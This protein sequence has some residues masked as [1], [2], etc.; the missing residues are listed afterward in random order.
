MYSRRAFLAALPAVFSLRGAQGRR[1]PNIL[2]FL[3]DDQ[4][5]D[6]AGFMGN[7]IL[8]TPAADRLASSGVVFTN[9]F[10]T[11]SICMSSRASILTGLYERCHHINLFT[12]PLTDAQFQ[13][14]FPGLLR[15]AGYRTGYVGKWGIGDERKESSRYDYFRAFRG[16]GELLMQQ[17]GKTIGSSRL[18]SAQAREFLRGC[19][20]NQPFCIQVSYNSPHAQDNA[21]WQY[22]YEPAHAAWY[23]DAV[24][25]VPETAN[26]A[27][28]PKFPQSVQRSELRRRWAP[29]FAT[30]ELFQESLRSYFRLITEIDESMG[31][32]LAELSKLGLDDNTVVIFASDNG[33]YYGEYGFAD[34]WLMHEPSIRIPMFL[35]DPRMRGGGKRISQMALNIDIAPTILELAGVPAPPSM[36]GRSLMPLVR[37]GASAWRRDWFYEHSYRHQGWIPAT[38][39]VRTTR[40]K[41]TR[42][43]DTQPLFEELFDLASDPLEKRNLAGDSTHAARLENLRARWQTWVRA[44]EN[45]R[46]TA[47][48]REPDPTSLAA[49]GD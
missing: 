10:V 9:A 47:P 26:P 12:T 20:K 24:I 33:Y 14:S 17:E 28:W 16:Q 41:Y 37:G 19:T 22:L 32:I 11:T 29:R 6:A 30:P 36:Q 4:R 2:F 27:Q 35:Y 18:L 5:W 48:W 46:P 1:P 42:Y 39:G 44:L 43:I 21:P 23:K 31:E 45:W 34:K 13:N 15:A 25:P 49:L 8:R 40:W 7:R 38:E 3:T